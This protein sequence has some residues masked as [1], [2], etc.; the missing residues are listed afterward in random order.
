MQV[1]SVTTIDLSSAQDLQLFNNTQINR[2][3]PVEGIKEV[4]EDLAARGNFEWSDKAKRRGLVYW[5]SPQQLGQ[6]IY[7]WVAST[8]QTGTVMTTAEIVEEGD[9]NSWRGVSQE[10]VIRAL[11][12]LQADK[13]CEIFD[14]DDG[15]KFF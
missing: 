13:K 14:G 8:G 3:L 12:T 6:D 11:Q 7:Q 1:N 10:V 9:T 5:R 4:L 15:V 2:R